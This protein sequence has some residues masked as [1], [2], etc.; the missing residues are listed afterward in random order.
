MKKEGKRQGEKDC[1]YET[2]RKRKR[3]ICVS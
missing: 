1:N 2:E 3:G